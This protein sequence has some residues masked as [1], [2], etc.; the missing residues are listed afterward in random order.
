VRISS[1]AFVIVLATALGAAC[2]LGGS[3][4]GDPD[5]GVDASPL[6]PEADPPG[7]GGCAAPLASGDLPC[8][9]SAVFQTHCQKCHTVPAPPPPN[10]APFPLKTYE[11]LTSPYG[12][13]LLRWQRV[14]QV[15]EDGG[16]PHMPPAGEP[17]LAPSDFDTL[18]AWFDACAPG[19]PEGT[20]CDVGE[21]A[22]DGAP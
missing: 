7:D 16:L 4:S 1:S 8:D 18:H 6:L 14:S 5:G 10:D 9:V 13:G 21:D 2:Y 11:D 20:G 22:G 3:P 12:T 19:L 17:E 15:I